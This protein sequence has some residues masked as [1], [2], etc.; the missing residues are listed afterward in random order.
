MSKS[1]IEAPANA[2]YCA[3]V[4]RLRNLHPLEGS[5]NLLGFPV[6][7]FQSILD[8]SHVDGELGVVFTAECQLSEEFTRLNNLHRKADLNA[9]KEATGYLEVNRRVRALK[10]RGHR[11]DCLFLPLECLGYTEFDLSTLSEGDC[12]DV[13][14]GHEIVKKYVVH[15]K[16]SNNQKPVEKK[17]TRVSPLLFPEHISTG[18]FWRTES[19]LDP[20]DWVTVT[21]KVHGTSW[22]GTRT[23]VLRPLTFRDRIAKRL[24]VKVDHFEWAAVAGSRKV[25]K[26][27][28]ESGQEHFYNHDLWTAYLERI[29]HVI[30]EGFVIYG[31]LI[32]WVDGNT[33]IQ[34]NYTYHL[35][36][37]THSLFI[38]RVATVNARGVTTDLSWLQVKEF[39]EKNGLEHVPEL[40][41]GRRKDFVP[42]EWIDI[43]LHDKYPQAL[44]LSP[45]KKLV[46]EGVVVRRDGL[47]PWVG[48]AK[49]PRFLAMETALLDKETVDIEAEQIEDAS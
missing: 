14:N 45:G 20:E 42:E 27:P 43:K 6:Y 17:F 12:F 48:K 8:K 47:T 36:E 13:L 37:G 32:G 46:D 9:D 3:T 15:R 21:Q 16:V 35:P 22:R 2:N 41:A 5:D 29:E 34:T 24:G 10:L 25:I 40:W 31:E 11:S 4:V 38:Y 44:P 28:D 30:P 49:S 39:C 19:D 18:N 33:P 7:G 23:Q 1:K 26:D